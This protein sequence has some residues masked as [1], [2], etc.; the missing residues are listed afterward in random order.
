MPE[1]RTSVQLWH[2]QGRT[3]WRAESAERLEQQLEIE[4]GLTDAWDI[5]LYSVFAQVDADAM[6]SEP[7][8]FTALKLATRYRL[9]ERAEWPVDTLLYAEASKQFGASIYVLETRLVLAR[10]FGDLT[11]A[12]NGVVTATVGPDVEDPAAVAGYALGATYQVN[13]M[14]RAGVETWGAYDERLAAS[15]GPALGLVLSP[16][17]WI[18]L[19]AGFGLRDSDKLAARAIVGLEL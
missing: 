5:G 10:D 18:A 17:L 3:S 19:T 2:S 15:A 7:F 12:A 16:Q 9:G 1:G 6:T 14:L 11:L 4:H 8:R 13:A